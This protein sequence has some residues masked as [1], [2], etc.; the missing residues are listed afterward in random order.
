MVRTEAGSGGNHWWRA[1]LGGH[2]H[3]GRSLREDRLKRL[4]EERLA[5]PVAQR[6]DD[7]GRIDRAGLLDDRPGLLPRPHAHDVPG[8]PHP[9]DDL[10]LLD[11][12]VSLALG[13]LERRVQRKMRDRK[14]TR[15]NSSHANISYAVFC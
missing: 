3:P 12:A 13:I 10:R 7:G 4:A 11:L 1:R 2:D 6:H 14:S 15:L 9:P 5:V 8:H